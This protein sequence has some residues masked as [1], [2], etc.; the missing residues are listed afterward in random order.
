M[1]EAQ[2]SAVRQVSS[3]RPSPIRSVG[4][5]IELPLVYEHWYVAGLADEFGRKPKAKTLL[6][7][8]IVFYR[9]EAGELTALQNRCLHRSFP[10]S[11]SAVKG[12]N[13]V[14]GY[15]GMEY[16]P[17]GSIVRIPCQDHTPDRKLRRYPV[18]TMGPFVFIWMG[19]EDADCEARLPR[20]DYLDDPRFDSVHGVKHLPGN[21][22]LL[23][24][25]LHDLTHFS[26][27]HAS[28]FA[29]G[30]H[31]GRLP[32]EVGHGPEGVFCH[33][34]DDDWDRQ[35]RNLPPD[36]KAR[37]AGRR[38]LNKNGGVTL[39]P[40]VFKG[41]SPLQVLG[42]DGEVE[43]EL[44][45]YVSHFV[46]PETKN[47]AHYW[48]SLHKD[49]PLGDEAARAATHRLFSAGFEEDTVA[50]RHMQRLLEEDHIEFEELVIAGDTAGMLH[51]RAMLDWVKAEYPEYR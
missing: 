1:S 47:T 9:T 35:T 45:T 48:W 15:H 4:D 19:E 8:S 44:S 28:T 10:L 6:E 42:D 27:L 5:Y 25:N 30:D 21:Y 50:I 16:R 51:R 32:V 22:L 34:L 18:R 29:I 24:E 11:E 38:V 41:Y 36:L 37:C 7:R 23:V 49:V 31:Y 20:M 12:D 13:L 26:Y 17:D 3:K 33:R 43:F 14:C 46:T 2:A 40:G 39:A